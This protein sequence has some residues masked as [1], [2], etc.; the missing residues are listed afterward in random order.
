MAEGRLLG[1]FALVL[2]K[3]LSTSLGSA[4]KD[5]LAVLVH[6]ELDDDDLAGVDTHID[7]GTVGLLSLDPLNVN[8]ELLP[9]TLNNLAD[10]LSLVVSSHYLNFIILPDGHRSDSILGSEFL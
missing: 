9:V 2:S 6:L 7:G 10:L 1:I 3:S 4:V 5:I 8:T